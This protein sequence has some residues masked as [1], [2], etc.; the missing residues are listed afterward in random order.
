[1]GWE[2]VEQRADPP[3]CCFDRAFGGLSQESFELRKDLL[4]GIE[5]GAVGREEEHPCACSSD[6]GAHGLSLV[7][8][9]II[10]DHDVAGLERGDQELL[11]I[12]KEA[13]AIDRAIEDGGRIDPIMPQR[14][15]KGERLPVTVWNLGAQPLAP[16]AAAMSSGHVSLGPGFIDEDETARIKPTLIAYP[17]CPPT[18]DIAPILLAGQ[19]AF[20]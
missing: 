14:G 17:A 20:F 11:D 4:D 19:N 10:E 6:G 2:C 13:D 7:A 16:A 18:R 8:T 1:M 9:Q 3:P 5:V 15:Q 12:G